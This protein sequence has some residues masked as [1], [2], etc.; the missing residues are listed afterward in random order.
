MPSFPNLTVKKI[1]QAVLARCEWGRDDYSLNV[2]EQAPVVAASEA[3]AEASSK[4]GAKT[5]AGGR[6][7]K[8]K[9]MQGLS[10]LDLMDSMGSEGRS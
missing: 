8:A 4:V 5:K 3:Q 2:S 10:L 6:S 9:P 1:P 7:K